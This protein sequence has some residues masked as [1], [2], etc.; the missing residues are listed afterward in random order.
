MAIKA[1]EE[2]HGHHHPKEA[3]GGRE[4]GGGHGHPQPVDKQASSKSTR[5]PQ[6]PPTKELPKSQSRDLSKHS[7]K[8]FSNGASALRSPGH[9]N[10]LNM[11]SNMSANTAKEP[12]LNLKLPIQKAD[13]NQSGILVSQGSKANGNTHSEANSPPAKSAKSRRGSAPSQRMLQSPSRGA[14]HGG[15]ERSSAMSNSTSLQK[16]TMP[17]DKEQLYSMP[18]SKARNDMIVQLYLQGK[19]DHAHDD[20]IKEDAEKEFQKISKQKK[21]TRFYL[22]KNERENILEK[23]D[24][25]WM[26][27]EKQEKYLERHQKQYQ[28]KRQKTL[29]DQDLEYFYKSKQKQ[30]RNKIK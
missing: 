29:Q 6:G 28:H 10:R 20:E 23:L 25:I 9:A 2:A 16:P 8:A 22:T 4:G 14:E 7:N 12:G 19:C 11:K 13:E 15:M 17:T 26:L 3:A 24:D 30:N 21:G 5:K 1:H 27:K 18:P